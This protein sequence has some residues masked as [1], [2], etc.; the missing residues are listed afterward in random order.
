LAQAHNARYAAHIVWS[1]VVLL[2]D[3][4][5]KGINIFS[6]LRSLSLRLILCDLVLKLFCRIFTSGFA[7][8]SGQHIELACTLQALF[9]LLY[10]LRGLPLLGFVTLFEGVLVNVFEESH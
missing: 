9:V 6:R 3:R 1:H 2:E 5:F 10:S 4:R 8:G 7:L